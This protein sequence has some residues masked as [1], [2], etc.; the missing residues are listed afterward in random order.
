MTYSFTSGGALDEISDATGD[1]LTSS[2]YSPVTGQ[3]SCPGGDTC[4][5]WAST[6]AGELA[7]SATLVEAF[8]SNGRLQS[9]F[10]AASSAATTQ[11]V[12]L[13]TSGTG[14]STW[15]GTPLDICTI[16]DP[17]SLTTTFTYDTSKSS[18]YNY[19]LITASP[20]STGEVS[21]TYNS[22]G[23]VTKQIITT[24]GT[25]Q[26]QD[27]AYATNSTV[28]NGTQTTVTDYPNGSSNP[29]TTATYLFSNNVEVGETNAGGAITYTDPD[30]ATLLSSQTI[31]GNGNSAFEAFDNYASSGSVTTSADVT[32]TKDA[33]GNVTDTQYTSA[34]LPWC[35]V[36]AADVA[37]GI[38]CPGTEPTSPP[39]A[40]TRIGY[41]LDIYNAQNEPTS[42]T[43][44]LG[45]TT[46]NA[47]TSG[48][49]GV[50]NGLLYCTVDPAN[51]ALGTRCPTSAPT[52]PP[53]G[54]T[55]YTAKIYNASGY[56]LSSS[57]PDGDT[58]S[59]TYG[60]A[61]NPGLPTVTIDPDGKVTTDTYNAQDEVLTQVVTD[62]SGTYSATTQFAY[63]SAGQKWCEVDPYE[64]SNSIRC[65]SS[66][67]TTPPT[68]TI[69]Y[70]DTIYNANGQVT[71]TTNP[72]GG[73]TQYAY[74]GSG[75][76]YCTVTPTNYAS[77]TRCPT[78]LPLTT[79][80]VG[81]DS[82]LGATI[83]TFDADNR[84]VQVTNPLGGITLNTYDN[85]NNL[86]QSTVES[87]NSTSAPNQVTK[88][89][90]DA[91]NRAISTTTGY[92]SSAPA[93]TLTSYD[94][95]G[96]AFCSVSANAYAAGSTTYQ[97]PTWQ[98]GWIVA[99]PTPTGTTP[100]YSTSPSSAQANNVTTTF[101]NADGTQ[102]QT[103]N[104]DVQTS[105]T[106]V[107]ADQR[108]YCTSDP[109]NVATWLTANPTGTYPYLCP[110]TPPTSAPTGTA[111]GYDTTLF[112]DAGRTL[113]STDQVGD[114]TTYTD[115]PAGNQLTVTDPRGKVT[116]NC[117]YGQT[118]TCAASAPAAG[119]SYD[120]LYSTTTPATSADPSGETTTYTYFPGDTAETTTT[121]AG[122][123]ADAYDADL[124]LTGSTYSDTASGYATPANVSYTYNVDGSRLTMVDASGTT[125]YTD[126][127]MGDVTQQQFTAGSGTGL[128]NTTVGYGYFTTGAESSVTY[129][130]YTGHSS[131]EATY[132]YDAL[133]NMATETDWLGN[134]VTF[135]H[136]QDGN[137]T[138]QDNEVS[139]TNSSGTSATAFSYD[140]ADE[141]TQAVSSVNCSGSSGTLTQ[142]FTGSSGSRNP[143]GQLTEDTDS[144]AS[145]C[146]GTSTQRNYS[147][148]QAGR[149]V[150][151]GSSVQGSSPN[152][153]I[154]DASGD[155]TQI[156]S[157]DTSGNL[158]SY[159]QSFDNAGETTG[160]TPVS[161]S[162]G[163]SST[164]SYDTLGD[165]TTAVTGSTTTTY[166]Y[167][168]TGQMTSAS[169]DTT[170][171]LYTGDGLQAAAQYTAPTWGSSANIDG[172]HTIDSVT[173]PTTTFCQAVDNDGN[174]FKYNGTSW[175]SA[176]DIDGTNAIDSVSCP[177]SSFC[178]AVD[179]NG[180]ALI[181]SGTAWGSASNIDG[182][183][184]IES[185]SCAS[186][187]FCEAVDNDGNRLKY[188]GSSWNAASSI[189]GTNVI[190]SVSCPTSSFCEAVDADG[191]AL[192][193]NG[194][195]WGSGA[196][197]DGTHVLKSV[198]CVSSSFCVTVDNDGNAL[199]YNGTSWAASDID[200]TTALDSVSCA[201]A[202][203]CSA[204]D[205]SGNDLTF[206]GTT[207]AEAIDIDG[208][209][210]LKSISC[211]SATLCM[212]VDSAGDAQEY[213]SGSV[214]AQLTWDT[215][216]SSPLILAD[217]TNDY[218]YG[219]NNEPVEQMNL[220]SSTP[221]YL[222]YTAS[223]SSWLA[224]NN[225]GQQVAFWG[226]DAFGNLA[227][228]TP[229]S[230][231]GYSG[232]YTDAST[233]LVN[234]RARFYQSQTGSFTTRDPAFSST[235]TAYT[236]SGGDP[237]NSSDPSGLIPSDPACGGNGPI[238]YSP[239]RLA[240]LCAAQQANSRQVVSEECKNNPGGCTDDNFCIGSVCLQ[241]NIVQGL[242]GG[243]NF[244]EGF[245]N[246]ELGTI[247]TVV[248]YASFGQL[249]SNFHLNP[250]PFC[251]DN[252]FVQT[253]FQAG[254]NVGTIYGF[255]P[256]NPAAD[257][258]TV[259]L[260]GGI[261]KVLVHG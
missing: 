131:P 33:E 22:S 239:G 199:T 79:P 70:T 21:N 185:V 73:T 144:Y 248:H 179:N 107:D 153:F 259:S 141:N 198:S 172:T 136:D 46:Q 143:D 55:G 1:I 83:D 231:F 212:A 119:G 218:I 157:H 165:Q 192:K 140:N 250:L 76:Q 8:N 56:L 6:P 11:I 180:N 176:A 99:P 221:T 210:T 4:T 51:Y 18:P 182:T 123:T 13:R 217:G 238:G 177:T 90:Y 30:P 206:N 235:D 193:Y 205:A 233:G 160:Q 126:D 72:L 17:G 150:Y 95:N 89:T 81:A 142:S 208:T 54:V 156:T 234:D 258:V 241:F 162:M 43:D 232:Q 86:T 12:K 164:Y 175:G 63:N 75:N 35:S 65:P 96:D 186:S 135:S 64:Y 2:T 138:A 242:E 85:A 93:T 246:A 111:A 60:S 151:Q 26:E 23:Q 139:G 92:G 228:G 41:T 58:T 245:G 74:D 223:D 124:D 195:S 236:Y 256:G 42:T 211:A 53:T 254:Q 14:C 19:D 132:T 209:N 161:G 178:A 112:D 260:Y 148:D 243:A 121:P 251:S 101:F 145:P 220:S 202:T 39:A 174:R 116:T 15:S 171:Y 88:T 240:Q 20:P 226:Y 230:P 154:Y 117:Y 201:T 49:S 130:S 229:D 184:A 115:D 257:L 244:I 29:S 38:T 147:Y 118:G 94:P 87:N 255:I 134:E 227:T 253:D 158:D 104:P 9:V 207:W 249:N 204:V 183:N 113:S 114:T 110:S 146:S 71:T 187:T 82:Y 128:A 168:Q 188:N 167:D 34:N 57:D 155:P 213:Q 216:G 169:P 31:D 125:T 36:D 84:V 28:T 37:D 103:T 106:A 196:T 24:G 214:T 127:A 189:D 59:Y 52:T 163:S 129:P 44:P 7:P 80:T 197:I 203:F 224:T 40:G 77:G 166:S 225:A 78:S 181:Y 91:D 173:C 170:S 149:V 108:T 252:P 5:A 67:P 215:N 97:C 61:A 120:D 32:Q 62:T 10:D 200:G 98:P 222:T 105:V 100:L 191:R 66:A 194:T 133:G 50:P 102:I 109:T 16:A 47:Y 48:V 261:I 69:G 137:L 25:N 122:T 190:D 219:P 152:N 68:G 237:V 45:N 159:T 247:N 27:F 3:A